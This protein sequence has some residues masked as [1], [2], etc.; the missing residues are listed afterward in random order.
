MYCPECG[1]DAEEAKFCPECGA[2]LRGLASDPACADVRER[3]PGRR[4]VLPRVR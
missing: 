3:D 2:D 4:Q 1:N